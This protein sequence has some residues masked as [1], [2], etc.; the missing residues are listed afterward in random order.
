LKLAKVR[1]KLAVNKQRSPRFHIG[2][3]GSQE[4][5]QDKGQ[6]EVY[7]LGHKY[8]CSFGRFG[9]WGGN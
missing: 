4:V 8:V 3:V 9:H 2:E 7:C 1:K 6:R 5:K